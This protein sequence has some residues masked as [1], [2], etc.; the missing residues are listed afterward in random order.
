MLRV[1]HMLGIDT[2]D[3]G[4]LKFLALKFGFA[5]IP[6]QHGSFA[7]LPMAFWK[8]A[9]HMMTGIGMAFSYIGAVVPLA[10]RWCSPSVRAGSVQTT[11]A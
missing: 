6:W 10:R 4:L 8:T 9:F 2:G 7:L 5:P 1:G 11:H 3:A